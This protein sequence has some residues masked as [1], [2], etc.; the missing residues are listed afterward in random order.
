MSGSAE[1]L[2]EYLV[3]LGFQTDA[4][5]LK[6]FEDGMGVVGK[7]VLGV[8]L[9]V[10]GIVASVEAATVAFAYS[11][12]R[13]YFDSELSGSSVKNMKAM[14][15]AGKQ[16]GISGETME[17]AIHGMAQAVRLNPGLK[18]L[19]ESFGVPIKGRDMSD[20]M[21]DFVKATKKM[22]EFVGAQYAGMFGI[23]PDTYHQMITHMDTLMAKKRE[24]LNIYKDSGVDPAKAKAAIMEFT[25]G[26]DKLEMRINL[27]GQALLI[28]FV[29]P[30]KDANKYLNGLIDSWMRLVNLPSWKDQFMNPMEALKD[31]KAR[32]QVG[33]YV[34]D[35]IRAPFGMTDAI[36]KAVTG[37][38]NLG[39]ND[40]QVSLGPKGAMQTGNKFMDNL[41]STYLGGS[42]SSPP[43][44]VQTQINVTSTA[45]ANQ[46]AKAV[47][48]KQVNVA[49]EITR[50]F[51]G[52]HQ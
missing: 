10:A 12:R 30:F 7:K 9:A 49:K 1:I 8:G 3:K 38:F 34:E 27:L 42:S 15:Y 47:A 16:I 20:V 13:V 21:L 25:Q 43:L 37:F 29:E 11:M 5:S 31:P 40:N 2:Q 24:A 52:N 36:A 19:V 14:E 39:G 33:H 35:A 23:D 28:K 22:P 6:K 46:V 48:D 51:K 26:L 50:N 17:S 32:A 44:V 41:G 45:N 18:G 4:I